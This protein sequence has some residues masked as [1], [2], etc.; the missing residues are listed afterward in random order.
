M[1]VTLL[2]STHVFSGTEERATWEGQCCRAEHARIARTFTVA[3]FN[4][5]WRAACY[6]LAARRPPEKCG[7]W[8]SDN[9]SQRGCLLNASSVMWRREGVH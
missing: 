4:A 3:G 8:I 7:L 9:R 2:S 6:A 1:F 5:P